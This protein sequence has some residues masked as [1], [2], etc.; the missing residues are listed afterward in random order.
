MLAF[1]DDFEGH[2]G[3]YSRLQRD[4]ITESGTTLRPWLYILERYKP[5]MLQLPMYTT[6]DT[7]GDHGRRYVERFA[8]QGNDEGNGHIEMAEV[9]ESI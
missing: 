3:Y 7:N 8:R 2:P 4:V 6:Y 1:L 9:C 5:E